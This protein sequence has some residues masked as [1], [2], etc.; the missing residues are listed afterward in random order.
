MTLYKR[1]AA[2]YNFDVE[3][4]TDIVEQQSVSLQNYYK[5]GDA[6]AIAGNWLYL[7]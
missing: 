5:G 7:K 1:R 2:K 6:V 3:W 4:T